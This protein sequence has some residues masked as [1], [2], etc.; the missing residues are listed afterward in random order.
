MQRFLTICLLLFIGLFM[1]L[2]IRDTDFGWH[3]RCGKELIDQGSLCL[4][5]TYSYY[6][7][8]YRAYYGSFV[9][10]SSIAFIYDHLG[11]TGLSILGSLVFV[12][13]AY[14]LYRLLSGPQ[15]LKIA[16]V[17]LFFLISGTTLTLGL[18]PQIVT[19][20]F[21]LLTL[22]I[23]EKA[24]KN[25]NVIFLLPL[26]FFVWVNTHIGFFI[27]F[28]AL[29][30][31]LLDTLAHRKK[32]WKYSLLALTLCIL[33]TLLNPFGFHIYEA[34]WDHVA[35]PLNTLVA[36]WMNPPLIYI[37]L[38]ATLSIL[39]FILLVRKK[40]ISMYPYLLLLAFT[41]L[42][43]KAIRNIPLYYAVLAITLSGAINFKKVETFID[44]NVQYLLASVLIVATF[45]TLILRTP[46]TIKMNTVWSDYC[47]HNSITRYPCDIADTFPNLTGNL[48]APYEY[49]GFLIWKMPKVK[50]FIDGRMPAWKDTNG[51][52]PYEAYLGVVQTQ[53]GWNEILK[54]T[55]TDY[56]LTHRG[57]FLEILLSTEGD[58]YGWKT[59]YRSDNQTL[60]KNY[61]ISQKHNPLAE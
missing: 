37:V 12:G 20:L 42:A 7:P 10:D 39:T 41:I 5:N 55:K 36:E 53:P 27:G 9:Y 48:F 54:K 22:F 56:V 3:Y 34:L 49:G 28:I 50:V 33:V 58:K 59:V 8:D 16:I 32:Q 45:L 40:A 26:L 2:P 13:I 44:E 35:I 14:L 47:F 23:I 31:F 60:F 61:S 57:T 24:Y 52:S 46:S 11:F 30:A 15:S 29:G 21:F 6:L 51:K 25:S 19:F 18:R 43:F 4:K 38:F 1:F 17:S